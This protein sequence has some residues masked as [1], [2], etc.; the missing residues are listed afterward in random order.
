MKKLNQKKIRWIIRH[1]EQGLNSAAV[2]RSQK[3]S[4]RRVQQIYGQYKE[5]NLVPVLRKPGRKAKHLAD[6]HAELINNVYEEHKIGP[7]ALEKMIQRE[8]KFISLT[9]QYTGICCRKDVFRRIQT[10]RNKESG[11]DTSENT[12][13][14]L[15]IRIGASTKKSRLSHSW[16]MHQEISFHAWNLMMRQQK[17]Q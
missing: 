12:H 9:M 17:T 7:V 3:I 5:T 15:Y 4:Q 16:M 11:C 14:R 13:Y 10:R 8:H 1:I 2:A 6:E